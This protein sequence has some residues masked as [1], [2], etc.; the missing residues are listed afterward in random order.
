MEFIFTPHAKKRMKE[1]DIADPNK[2]I[3][4]PC[5][6]KLKKKIRETCKL[7]GTKTDHIYW[8]TRTKPHTIF[9]T[10]Q[11][12]IGKYEVVTAFVLQ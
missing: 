4:M 7:N 11:L 10:R 5:G 2:W 12:D 1:R 6:R 3:L 9:V 8:T